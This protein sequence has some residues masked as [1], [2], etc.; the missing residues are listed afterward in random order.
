[1]MKPAYTTPV[2]VQKSGFV[3]NERTSTDT[4]QGNF[5]VCGKLEEG[6]VIGIEVFDCTNKPSDHD[7]IVKLCRVAQTFIWLDRNSTT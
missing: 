5:F 3:K 6:D 2:P 1:M 7:N 4:Y